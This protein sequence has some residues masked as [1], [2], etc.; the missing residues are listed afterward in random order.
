MMRQPARA[1]IE[2]AIRK[3]LTSEHGCDGVRA[4][5]DLPRKQLR[6]CGRRHRTH[7]L[8]PATNDRA[9]LVRRKNVQTT[10]LLIGVRKDSQKP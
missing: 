9:P 1:G 7:G 4:V 3:A 6:Q 8:V 2:L 10:D 5:L